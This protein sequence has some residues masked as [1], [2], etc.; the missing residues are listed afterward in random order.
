MV[1]SMIGKKIYK[2][3][4]GKKPKNMGAVKAGTPG[5]MGKPKSKGY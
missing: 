1:V 4:K 2:K 3:V 5:K